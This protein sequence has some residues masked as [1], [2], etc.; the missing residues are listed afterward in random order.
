MANTPQLNEM[1]LQ[2][3][4]NSKLV[5]FNQ[6]KNKTGNNTIQ[7]MKILIDDKNIK[8]LEIKGGMNNGTKRLL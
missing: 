8:Q 2:N 7:Q 4:K 3:N 5:E 1:K 6:F